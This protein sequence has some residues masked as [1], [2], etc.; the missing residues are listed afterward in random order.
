MTN[1]ENFNKEE[2]YFENQPLTHREKIIVL[3]KAVIE[4]DHEQIDYFIDYLQGDGYEML[5]SLWPE[6]I[7]S[8]NDFDCV[9]AY[10][11]EKRLDC[12]ALDLLTDW[13]A[14]NATK[15]QAERFALNV[16]YVNFE[17][18]EECILEKAIIAK[19]EKTEIGE[20]TIDLRLS[21]AELD[22]LTDHI[23]E[24]EDLDGI[25][26]FA[27]TFPNANM[28]KLEVA[29]IKN[30][31]INKD[32]KY[33]YLYARDVE[34]VDHDLIEHGIISCFN[35]LAEHEKFLAVEYLFNYVKDVPVNNQQF[36]SQSILDSKNH[37]YIAYHIVY[38]D[39]A[40]ILGNSFGNYED[41]YNFSLSCRDFFGDKNTYEEYMEK[42]HQKFV[43]PY[44][45][46]KK[47]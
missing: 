32:I 12:E 21:K 15:E 36:F 42:L 24:S 2:N 34:K 47:I 45:K 35:H 37:E 6:L 20:L 9:Y 3:V 11:K 19:K 5:K 16:P 40:T 31:L 46:A 7:I 18:L 33:L 17:K 41:L 27:V 39:D 38:N 10:A 22:T 30:S 14:N 23:V 44:Q 1:K 8:L 25:Y 43:E 28:Q 13:V 26:N 29:L 4:Q